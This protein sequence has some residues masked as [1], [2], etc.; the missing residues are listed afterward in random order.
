MHF[1]LVVYK[2]KD[3][4][5][6]AGAQSYPRATVAPQKQFLIPSY[7]FIPPFS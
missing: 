3:G 4:S 1:P 2:G 7:P 6:V 5:R